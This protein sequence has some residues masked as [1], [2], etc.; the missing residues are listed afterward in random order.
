M[1][2]NF[3]Q[4]SSSYLST[5]TNINILL[6]TISGA[7]VIYLKKRHYILSSFYGVSS[8][9]SIFST[10]YT[11]YITRRLIEISVYPLALQKNYTGPLENLGCI[12]WVDMAALFFICLG[13]IGGAIYDS[14]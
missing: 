6:V 5:I 3:V 14:K 4:L 2:S 8:L 12:F 11:L 9:L 7:G 10:I 13:I 1:D